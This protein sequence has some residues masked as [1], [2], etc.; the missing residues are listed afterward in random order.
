MY[1]N[2]TYY[3]LS[4]WT[5]CGGGVFTPP[6]ASGARENSLSEL[7]ISR[8]SRNDT[9]IKIDL[10]IEIFT[11]E[12]SIIFDDIR[13]DRKRPCRLTIN[14]ALRNEGMKLNEIILVAGLFR[15]AGKMNLAINL[16]FHNKTPYN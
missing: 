11:D 7:R 13:A 9:A 3:Y 12:D 10:N 5:A 8:T 6:N 1:P 4:D 16:D 15:S 2:P 14:T